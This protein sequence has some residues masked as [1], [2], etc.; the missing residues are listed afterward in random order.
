MELRLL[1]VV[2][3]SFESIMTMPMTVYNSAWFDPANVTNIL[4]NI[5]S[6]TTVDACACQCYNNLLCFTG[7]FFGINK[8]CVLFSAHL[9]QGNLRLIT[10]T[11]ASVFSFPNRTTNIGK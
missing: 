2:L 5:F 8:T 3:L 9:W 4:I 6:V 7:T 11:F 10:N 1:L